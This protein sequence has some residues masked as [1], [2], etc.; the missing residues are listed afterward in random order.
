MEIKEFVSILIEKKKTVL[1]ILIAGIIVGILAKFVF[2]SYYETNVKFMVL[3]SKMIRRN[4]EGKKLDIDTY[5]NFVNNDS[6]YY[7]AYKK[8]DIEKKFDMDFD[9]FTECFDVVSVEDTAIIVLTVTFPDKKMSY[10]IAKAVAEKV[11]EINKD[12]IAKEIKSGYGFAEKQLEL[13]KNQ[14]ENARKQLEDFLEKNNVFLNAEEIELARNTLAVFSNGYFLPY[15]NT[16]FSLLYEKG[17]FTT[18]NINNPESKFTSV[19]DINQKILDLQAKLKTAIYDNQKM[20]I[21][22]EL[23]F[24]LALKNEKLKK[25]K[26]LKNNMQKLQS[27]YN[28]QKFQYLETYNTFVAS[29]KAYEKLLNDIMSIKIEIA[30]KTKEMT[31]LGDL[32]PPQKPVFPR[33]S[34][35]LIAGVFLALLIDFLYILGLGFYRKLNLND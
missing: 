24:Y 4:L 30:G 29:A 22:R 35:T 26:E 19:F 20:K 32:V 1:L 6:V 9:R 21:K 5:L 11:L 23:K 27:S 33:L 15:T 25:I 2:P 17:L 18:N 14:Y 31:V 13:A 7:Y 3:E 28:K 16:E 12:I 8:L 10:E 34:I